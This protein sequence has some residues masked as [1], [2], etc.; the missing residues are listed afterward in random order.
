MTKP[1]HLRTHTTQRTYPQKLRQNSSKNY[2]ALFT[3]TMTIQKMK[4]R[5][6]DIRIEMIKKTKRSK[7][8]KFSFWEVKF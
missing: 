5:T 1:I 8:S 7:F 4:R 2:V 3:R 6:M